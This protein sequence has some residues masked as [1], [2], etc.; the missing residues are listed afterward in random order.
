MAISNQNYFIFKFLTFLTS[1]LE[2]LELFLK[3]KALT[4]INLKHTL[5]QTHPN[6]AIFIHHAATQNWIE[7][8]SCYSYKRAHTPRLFFFF[9][10][11]E[12]LYGLLISKRSQYRIPFLSGRETRLRPIV[13]PIIKLNHSRVN[14]AL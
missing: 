4:I 5:S 9:I 8:L 11:S 12:K 3:K 14:Y 1:D 7:L 10:H 13:R 6:R 2:T